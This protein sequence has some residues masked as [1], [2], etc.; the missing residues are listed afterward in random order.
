MYSTLAPMPLLPGLEVTSG[1]VGFPLRTARKPVGGYIFLMVVQLA[2]LWWL[3]RSKQIQSLDLRVWF[4]CHELE[5][6]RCVPTPDT[7]RKV[8]RWKGG[9]HHLK[10]SLRRLE[11]VG[12]M[13]C[14]TSCRTFFATSPADLPDGVD[15]AGFSTMLGK[16]KNNRRCVPFPRQIV[17]LIAQGC[18]PVR[19]AT[20]L[21]HLFRCLYYRDGRCASGGRCKAS[22]IADVFGV[23]RRNVKRERKRL[24]DLRLLEPGP[25][26][27]QWLLNRHGSLTYVSLTW[28]QADLREANTC[29]SDVQD[30]PQ[31]QLP[32]PP[33]C[34]TM[35]LPPPSSN[36]KLFSDYKH[37]KQ[38]TPGVLRPPTMQ[39][40]IDADLRDPDRTVLLSDDACARG[41]IGPND[42]ERRGFYNHVEH[43]K[44]YGTRNA[45]G[46]L[47]ANIRY[48]RS[49]VITNADEDGS[50]AL[51]NHYRSRHEA[52]SVAPLAPPPSAVPPPLTLPIRGRGELEPHVAVIDAAI[53]ESL[54]QAKA[55]LPLPPPVEEPGERPAT[56]CWQPEELAVQARLEEK[57]RLYAG[58]VWDGTTGYDPV[59][60]G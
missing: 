46:M 17:R 52:R 21:G 18:S 5:A 55:G 2:L 33:V 49:Q 23:D 24:M 28:N 19:I 36:Q 7:L 54:A 35:Q 30:E 51:Y 20:L 50:K 42:H 45:P 38:E 10:A 43:A 25:P 29:C 41:L 6:Q 8:L 9:N 4:A 32:P 12:L 13:R 34:P 11:D 53:A 26:S 31:T 44:T 1:Q 48:R 14:S 37:Q 59:E 57:R 15:L 47:A 58:D 40:I 27:P 39:H 3:Q 56:A 22:W 16:I 60:G